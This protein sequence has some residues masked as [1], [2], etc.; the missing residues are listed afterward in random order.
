M[1]LLNSKLC[2]GHTTHTRFKPIN[3]HFK[4]NLNYLYIDLSERA[5]LSKL[6]YFNWGKNRFFSCDC[7]TYLAPS[8]KNISDKL[9]HLI[10]T[11]APNVSY[12]K[13]F[14]L[15]TPRFFGYTF[16][17]VSFF[18]LYDKRN[19]TAVVAEVHNTFKEKAV[20]LLHSPKINGDYLEFKHSKDLHV[21]PFFSMDGDYTFLFGTKPDTIEVHINY[22]VKTTTM[23]NAQ[24]KLKKSPISKFS[25][26][27]NL[28]NLA[29]TCVTTFARISCQALQLKFKH[30]LTVTPHAGVHANTAWPR[31]P[32]SWLQQWYASKIFQY[33]NNIQLGALTINFPNGKTQHFG[34]KNEPN[35]ATIKVHHRNFFKQ[36]VFNGDLG[37]AEAYIRGYWST[38]NLQQVFSIFITNAT[39]FPVPN[40][41]EKLP[42]WLAVFKHKLKH[43]SLTHAKKNIMEH[44]DLGNDFFKLFLDPQKVYSSAIFSDPSQPLEAAQMN[45]IDTAL[46]RCDVQEHHKLIEIG[47]GWGALA[48]RAAQTIG[49]RVTT[50]TIS[51]AQYQYVKS[52]INQLHLDHLIEVKSMDYRRVTGEFDR[53]ISIEMIEAVG[54]KYLPDFI[55]KCRQLL[56]RNGKACFQ[57]I[58]IPKNRYADYIKS[59]DYIRHYIFPGGHLPTIEH[60]EELATNNAFLWAQATPITEHYVTTLNIWKDTF[61]EKKAELKAM[62][63]DQAFINKW[64]YYFDYCAAGFKEN[65]IETYQFTLDKK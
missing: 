10:N 43:N 27:R 52:K 33:L 56:K 18:Y 46:R 39:Y 20:Y 65:Y 17:P 37:L 44:Y 53:L 1:R 50:I 12:T 28:F 51:D 49:C 34:D 41:L 32:M 63:F 30:K 14:L 19:L 25:F 36:C 4:Y 3:R 16:N 57:A 26:V 22:K 45:K 2:K 54:H 55:N 13:A 29:T 5:K 61:L 58:T 6:P 11:K 7:N 35:P 24:L 23:F 21:S 38:P 47:S 62:G 48:I 8:K 64:V 40:F 59:T 60:L 15:T 9:F 31:Q 42:K